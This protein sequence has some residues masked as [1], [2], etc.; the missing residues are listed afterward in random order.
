MPVRGSL[1]SLAMATTGCPVGQLKDANGECQ[2]VYVPEQQQQQQ[3]APIQGKKG[4]LLDDWILHESPPTDDYGKDSIPFFPIDDWIPT[5]PIPTEPFP[6]EPAPTEPAATDPITQKAPSHFVLD[7]N[8]PDGGYWKEGTEST[9]IIYPGGGYWSGGDIPDKAMEYYES[10]GREGLMGSDSSLP[11][12]PISDSITTPLPSIPP[13]APMPIPIPIP[14][15][16]LPPPIEEYNSSPHGAGSA[17]QFEYFLDSVPPGVYTHES[18]L[19]DFLGRPPNAEELYMLDLHN[20]QFNMPVIDPTIPGW[21]P[22]KNNDGL[23]G[24]V[25]GGGLVDQPIWDA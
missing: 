16:S 11:I 2:W 5:E 9:W 20:N 7:Y 10:L 15:N 8:H 6:I 1:A 25:G 21:E 23:L 3:D 24:I 4:G 12:I 17:D 22:P 18:M 19:Q 13:P 14:D